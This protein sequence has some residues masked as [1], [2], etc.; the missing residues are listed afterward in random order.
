MLRKYICL[1]LFTLTASTHASAE[2][3]VAG[4]N[5]L[6]MGGVAA[7]HSSDNAAITVNPGM[8]AL[9]RRYDF[10]G[11]FK[12]GPS[13]GTHWAGS[14]VDGQT[15]KVLWVGVAYAGD[16]YNPELRPGELPGWTVPGEEIL[17]TKRFH[18]LT[19]AV[20]VP[21]V[22]ERVALGL[23]GG[24]SFYNHE[25]QGQGS[26]GNGDVGLGILATN[27]LSIGI[28]GENLLPLSGDRTL[29]AIAGVRLFDAEIGAFEIDGGY[30]HLDSEGLNIGVGGEKNAGLAR[31]R[32][33]YDVDL[34]LSEQ[35][36]SWGLG[37]V[38]EGGSFGYAMMLPVGPGEPTAAGLVNQFSIT[39]AAPDVSG[40]PRR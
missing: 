8:M 14:A 40:G 31:L 26:T 18:D 17:N 23:N 35:H 27:W 11:H 28:A 12:Y 34:G 3:D 30:H 24:V 36:V 6:G 9:T 22:P 38:G 39:L 1:G 19:L 2:E 13:K 25:R 37:L 7:A 4:A 10:H 33:G 29:G 15:S 20:S 21:L 5:V 16:A 32:V